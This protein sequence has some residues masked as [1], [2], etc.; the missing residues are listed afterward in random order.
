M[1]IVVT[2]IISD[3]IVAATEDDLIA[4]LREDPNEFFDGA[5]W[6]FYEGSEVEAES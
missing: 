4:Y 1:K 3:D 5:T 2:K 6:A